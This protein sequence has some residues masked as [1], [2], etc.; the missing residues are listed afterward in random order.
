MEDT[1]AHA[2]G[3]SML[4]TKRGTILVDDHNC[5]ACHGFTI[6]NAEPPFGHHRA[7][8]VPVANQVDHPDAT[9]ETSTSPDTRSHT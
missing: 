3:N 7:T 2:D 4:C 9:A 5:V 6:H 1:V 8:G